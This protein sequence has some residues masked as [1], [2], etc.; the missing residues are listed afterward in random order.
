M[1]RA[2]TIAAFLFAPLMTPIVIMAYDLFRH[3]LLD[4]RQVPFYFMAYGAFAYV[5]TLLFGIPALLLFRWLRWTNI[6]L[7]IMGGAVIGLIVSMFVME[8]Y[9]LEYFMQRIGERMLCAAAGAL[10]ALTFR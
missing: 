7:F 4:F 2:R 1:T 8:G 10:S 5:A 9:T 3:V 6:L